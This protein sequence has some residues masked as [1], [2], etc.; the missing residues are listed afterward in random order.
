MHLANTYMQFIQFDRYAS[1]I[2]I[3]NENDK[4]KY[5]YK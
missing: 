5:I 1:D 2:C 3:L 4:K